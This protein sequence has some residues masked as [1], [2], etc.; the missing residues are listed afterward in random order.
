MWQLQFSE[1]VGAAK[2]CPPLSVLKDVGND[3]LSEVLPANSS[4]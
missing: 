3:K 4:L 1:F 2:I